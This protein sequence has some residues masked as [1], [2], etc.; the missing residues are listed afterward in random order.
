LDVARG[1][2]A[3]FGERVRAMLGRGLEAREGEEVGVERFGGGEE[4]LFMPGCR[5]AAGTGA[6]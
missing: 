6:G 3:A 2:T 1:A 4:L 5:F